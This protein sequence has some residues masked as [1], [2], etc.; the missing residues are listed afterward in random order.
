MCD[1]ETKGKWLCDNFVNE[2]SN[3]NLNLKNVMKINLKSKDYSKIE[4]F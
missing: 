1:R 3:G 4:F 2:N